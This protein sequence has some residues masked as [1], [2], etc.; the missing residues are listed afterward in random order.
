MFKLGTNLSMV[1]ASDSQSLLSVEVQLKTLLNELRSHVYHEETFVHPL[2]YKKFPTSA[3]SLEHEHS[4][5]E[6][7]LNGLEEGYNYL[8]DLKPTH[9]KIEAQFTEFYRSFNRFVAEYLTHINE[10]E[11][12][13]QNLWEIAAHEELLGAMI[14]FLTYYEIAE[15]RTWLSNHLPNMSIDERI[16]MFKTMQLIAPQEIFKSACGLTEE[17]LGQS[18]WDLINNQLAME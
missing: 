9:P 5:L 17:I 6:L 4:E 3:K 15:S 14:S 13:M 8:I 16:L 2:L 10:E 12:I 7:I 11:Y 1:N 18:N